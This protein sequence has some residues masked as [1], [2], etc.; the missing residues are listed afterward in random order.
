MR[1][2]SGSGF[3][4]LLNLKWPT[5][6]PAL[7]TLLIVLLVADQGVAL[8]RQIGS[9]LRPVLVPLLISLAIAYLLEPIVE[10]FEKKQFS[11]SGSILLTMGVAALVLVL[12]VVFLVP[13]VG[14]QL[15]ESAQKLPDVVRSTIEKVK[16]R[17][18]ALQRLNPSA[19]AAVSERLTDYIKNPSGLTEPVVDWIKRGMLGLINVTSGILDLILIP[20]FVYYILEDYQK[21]R[22]GLYRLI[23]PR[24]QE[25]IAVLFR[26]ADS[27]AS[28]FVRGQLTVCLAMAVFYVIGFLICGAP[29]ALTLGILSGLGNL[30]PYVGTL[31]TAVLTISLT[32]IERPEWWRI[33]GVIIV[34]IGV[35]S[36]EGFVLT[37]RIL[38]GRLQLHPFIVIVGVIIGGSLFGIPGII[39]A[40]PVVAMAKVFLLFAYR[41]Y[42]D[43]DFYNYSKVVLT[44]SAEEETGEDELETS[45]VEAK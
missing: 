37:P 45:R 18:E 21:L 41:S 27:V 9:V 43:S 1:P 19:Y 15:V 26:D 6:L 36:L 12:V 16:P 28:N 38:G 35:Q 22:N 4:R 24:H 10:L 17:L 39:L 34:Y 2:R 31:A 42:L 11:R 3:V 7:V 32:A 23:P 29:L 33:I 25:S 40:T 30:I 20:F 8:L 44:T 13:P 14:K 5:V